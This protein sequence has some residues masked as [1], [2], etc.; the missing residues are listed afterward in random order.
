MMSK[1]KTKTRKAK[2]T[3]TTEDAP[4]DGFVWSSR[5]GDAG[6][7]ASFCTTRSSQARRSRKKGLRTFAMRTLL[8]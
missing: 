7:G 4:P 3:K 8:S 5:H 6:R 2:K 1:S